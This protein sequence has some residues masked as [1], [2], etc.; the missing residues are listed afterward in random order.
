[1]QTGSL[2]KVAAAQFPERIGAPAENLAAATSAIER[3]AALGARI[4]VLPECCIS[5]YDLDWFREGAPGGGEPVPGPSSEALGKVSTA[6]AIAVVVNLLERSEGGLYSTSVVIDSGRI[7]GLHRKTQVTIPE[8]RAG[9]RAG[10]QRAAP[11]AIEGFPLPVAPMIC[12]EHGFPE[13]A[14]GLAL[15]G[16]GVIA[17]SSAIRT[18]FEY[19]HNLRTRARAQDNGLYVVAANAVGYGYCGESMI[20]D[21]RG[22]VIALASPA[23][24]DVIVAD[25]DPAAVDQ[26]RRLEPVLDRRRPELWP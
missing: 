17:I 10:D 22:D 4:V 18:G 15:A 25:V 8:E 6:R 5:G 2:M 9:L 11:A 3:A 19:L 14:L 13:I 24:A 21:P 16:T 7:L 1:M 12:F 23:D 26:Q 20:V